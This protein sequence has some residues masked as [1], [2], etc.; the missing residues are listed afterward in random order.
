MRLK[1]KDLAKYREGL[2]K[3]QN[4]H[5]SLCMHPIKEGMACLDHDHKTGHVRTVLCKPCNTAE[6]KILGWCIRSGSRLPLAFIQRLALYWDIDFTDMPYHPKH[7][8]SNEKEIKV[9]RKKQK[10]LKTASA[11]AR[12]QVRID[13]LLA[14]E[15]E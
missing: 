3:A 5:C 10:K 13:V 1:Q 4:G 15:V 7:L 9:L 14:Q 8:T 11:V 2:S 12:Y 6:G